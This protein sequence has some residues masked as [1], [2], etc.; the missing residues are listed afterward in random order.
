M[1]IGSMGKEHGFGW[2]AG[3]VVLIGL[4]CLVGFLIFSRAV[5]A[6]GI[7]GAL[8]LLAVALLLFGWIYDRRLDQKY[9]DESG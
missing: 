1:A 9:P 3:L 2:L 6:F 7:F 8:I 4:G 5:Y